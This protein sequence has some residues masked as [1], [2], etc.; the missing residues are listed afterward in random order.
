MDKRT[1][2]KCGASSFNVA[3]PIDWV[4]KHK[5]EKGSEVSIEENER[6]ELVLSAGCEPV[7]LQQNHH[8]IKINSE[9]SRL[10]YWEL[11]RAY[12]RNYTSINLE[13]E[14]ISLL[15][16]PELQKLNSFIGL[17]IIERTKKVVVLKNFSAKDTETSPY[18]LVKKLDVGVR[19]MIEMIK[20]FFSEG[21]SQ[22]RVLELQSQHEYNER[23]YLFALKGINNAIDTPALMRVFKTDYKQ[24]MQEYELIRS[25]RQI[26]SNLAKM[27]NLLLFVEHKSKGGKLF[28]EMFDDICEKYLVVLTFP[29]NN[30]S[31]EILELLNS[32][33]T[34][35]S[36]WESSMKDIK[37]QPLVELFIYGIAINNA[38]DQ[39]ALELMG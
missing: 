11:L 24:L 39:L 36:V 30:L 26:S 14:N 21:F 8:T 25:L 9:S 15:A 34:K 7:A 5:L 33:K 28:N 6:G 29:K 4:R 16:G 3:V 1:L 2:V 19:A 31:K 37:V 38:L 27:G 32:S 23:I 12:L 13:G 17:D 20:A 18:L 22:E 35:T 10:L